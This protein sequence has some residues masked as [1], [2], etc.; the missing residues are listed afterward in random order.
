MCWNPWPFLNDVENINAAVQSLRL[1]LQYLVRRQA[2]HQREGNI[3]PCILRYLGDADSL[4]KVRRTLLNGWYC[5]YDLV[6]YSVSRLPVQ[7]QFC[8]VL[9]AKRCN[10]LMETCSSNNI[11]MF[12]WFNGKSGNRKTIQGVL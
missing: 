8:A 11:I 5:W 4:V 9:F 6:I 10:Y 7:Y 12:V 2:W 3:S 1:G